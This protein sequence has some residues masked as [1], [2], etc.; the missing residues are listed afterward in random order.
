LLFFSNL[1]F[2]AFVFLFKLALMPAQCELDEL[3]CD[4]IKLNCDEE[5]DEVV[6][7]EQR[8]STGA[9]GSGTKQKSTLLV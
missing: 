9:A 8:T 6:S 2:I 4:V 3:C 7:K 1:V 5:E